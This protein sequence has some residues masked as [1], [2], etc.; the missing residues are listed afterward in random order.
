MNL[1]QAAAADIKAGDRVDL[2]SALEWLRKNAD[3]PIDGIGLAI[4]LAS[5]DYATVTST[6][7]ER[8]SHTGVQVSVIRNSIYDIAV[9]ADLPIDRVAD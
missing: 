7:V 6:S 5:F 3:G 8:H 9:P 4:D 2:L 1:T